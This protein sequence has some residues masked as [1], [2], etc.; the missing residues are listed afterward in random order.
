MPETKDKYNKY[1]QE[2]EKRIKKSLNAVSKT[3][4]KLHKLSKKKALIFHQ[5]LQLE[6]DYKKALDK[7]NEALSDHY[8]ILNNIIMG[9][10]VILESGDNI[11]RVKELEDKIKKLSFDNKSLKTEV[12]EKTNLINVQ[13]STLSHLQNKVEYMEKDLEFHS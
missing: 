10:H 12:E 11:N 4:E 6:D 3:R 8:H 7:T 9:H 1:I 5:L 2:D 13:T